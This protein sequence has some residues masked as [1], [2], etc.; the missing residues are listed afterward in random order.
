MI[1]LRGYARRRL[2]GASAVVK[3]K[4]GELRDDRRKPVKKPPTSLNKS[5][6][7]AVSLLS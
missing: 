2:M 5:A 1:F 7:S 3:G 6:P 4:R